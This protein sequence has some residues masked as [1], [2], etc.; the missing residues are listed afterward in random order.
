M[1]WLQ[2]PDRQR[3]PKSSRRISTAFD[4]AELLEDYHQAAVKLCDPFF[5]KRLKCMFLY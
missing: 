5:N 1:E 4:H 2:R 3:L